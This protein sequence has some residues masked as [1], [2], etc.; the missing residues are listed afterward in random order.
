MEVNEK[1]SLAENALACCQH[2]AFTRIMSSSVVRAR[3]PLLGLAANEKLFYLLSLSLAK[4]SFYS[5][6]FSSSFFHFRNTCGHSPFIEARS[7]DGSDG[8]LML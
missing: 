7:R 8:L 1:S 5:F 2:F 6:F 4:A 3:E